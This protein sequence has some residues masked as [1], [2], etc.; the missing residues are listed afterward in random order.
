[1]NLLRVA[2]LT[3]TAALAC[4]AARAETAPLSATAV[5]ANN[6]FAVHLYGRLAKRPGNLCFSPCS[7]EL[8]GAM[9]YA[10]AHG[11]T[12][13]QMAEALRFP[14]NS[15]KMH[16]A[17]GGLLKELNLA[18]DRGC[19]IVFANSLWGQE[20]FHFLTDFET[21]CRECYGAPLVRVDFE[22]SLGAARQ[23]IND[24]VKAQT[25]GGIPDITSA[26]SPNAGTVLA[27]INAAYFSGSWAAKFERAETEPKSF[28]LNS[29]DS[30]SVPMMR[31]TT[32]FAYAER[33]TF[34][35]LELPYLSNKLSMIVILP[36][37]ADGLPELEKEL[38]PFLIEELKRICEE[39]QVEVWLPRFRC[40]SGLDL[41][42]PLKAM[43]MKDGF[44]AG[45]ANF[46]GIASG[47]GLFIGAAMHK[48]C[49]DVDEEGT[50][51]TA[52]TYMGFAKGG[53]AF[54]AANHPFL[55]LIRHNPTGAVLFLGRVANPAS[56]Y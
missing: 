28:Y 48:A 5:L 25:H 19:Q 6:A 40:T 35:V 53:T 33:S 4:A 21:V 34:K 10:G 42:G 44:S 16:M 31:N 8:A 37:D 24:W 43:G 36:K 47:R 51:A 30:I 49:V 15:P 7:I 52:A 1:M 23:R 41:E 56:T 14:T 12:A 13:Q 26:D 39:K 32:Y 17:F 54:F 20:R 38:T 11:R 46:S 22:G 2:S 9:A 50:V 45:E 18:N 55:F 27:L 29:S 3:V